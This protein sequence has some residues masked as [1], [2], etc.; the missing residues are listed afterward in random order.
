MR[1]AGAMVATAAALLVAPGTG[2]LVA[3]PVQLGRSHLVVIVGAAGGDVYQQVFHNWAV[4]LID[5]AV[6]ELGLTPEQVTYLGENPELDPEKMAGQSS[7]ENVEHTF[8]RLA[9]ETGPDDQI[10][11][12][13]I[14]HGSGE[15]ERSRFNIPGR[16]ITAVEYDAMLDLFVTQK[17]GFVNTASASGDF[18]TVLSGPNRVIVTATRDGRQYNQTVFPRFFVEA[19]AQDVADL[20]KDERVSLLEAYT[21][22][23]REVK[24]FYED[25]GRMLTE[26]SQLE[27][28]GDG[29]G[30][31]EPLP[32]ETDGALARRMF[33]DNPMST[34]NTAAGLTTDDPQL[35]ALYVDQRGLREQIEG[36]KLL[37]SS[38]DPE[39]YDTELEKLLISM[40]RTDQEI[41][42]RGVGW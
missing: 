21:Y 22:A 28:S 34:L 23:S 1:R 26:T 41:R 37:K 7:R 25:D 3:A 38:M 14:G 35:R 2:K 6:D 8:T 15:G 19:F 24:R 27:D 40:A 42:A 36:L 18:T 32:G 16:D 17:I 30:S 20:D 12:V 4:Q 13:L 5:A 11:V 31:Y 29:E 9:S 10:F 33:L 39:L